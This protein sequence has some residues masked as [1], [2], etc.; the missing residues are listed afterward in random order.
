MKATYLRQRRVLSYAAGAAAAAGDRDGSAA[1][2]RRAAELAGPL[3]AVPLLQQIS[4]LARR[5]R[6]ELTSP[7]GGQDLSGP[8]APFGLTRR[9][10]EVLRLVAAGRGN[11]DIAAELFIS[12][13]TVGVHVSN[14]LGKLGV[15]SRTEAA[16]IAHQRHLLDQP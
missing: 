8:A 15:S 9:E 7:A 13:R 3:A 5:A 11:R 4:D 10:I 6:I 2:L 1:R 16:A 12:R 14:I